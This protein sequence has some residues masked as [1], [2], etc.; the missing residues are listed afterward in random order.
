MSLSRIQIGF[1][2]FVLKDAANRL[3]ILNRGKTGLLDAP[4]SDAEKLENDV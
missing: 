2:E 1:L 3:Q 4:E